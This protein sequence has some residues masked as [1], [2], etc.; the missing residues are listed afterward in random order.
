VFGGLFVLGA[1]YALAAT[2]L[3]PAS[4]AHDV[5]HA[6]V[7]RVTGIVRLTMEPGRCFLVETAV[8]WNREGTAGSEGPGGPAGAAGPP[9]AP[10][11]AGPAG[12]VGPQGP[13]GVPGAPGAMG[14]AGPESH[15]RGNYTVWGNT[16]CGEGRTT[17][18]AGVIA[19]V[20]GTGGAT[21]PFC[22]SSNATEAG[23]QPFASGLVWRANASHDS[24]T[25]YG[26]YANGG[27]E[28]ECAVCEGSVYAA[29]GDGACASGYQK[30][31]SGFVSGVS[32]GVGGKWAPGGPICLDTSTSSGW[33]DWDGTF[34]ARAVATPEARMQYQSQN[35]TECTV[36][37]QP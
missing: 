4:A 21:A 33:L 24:T 35:A 37:Y 13:P 30:L 1:G 7:N 5:I 28:F 26:Q 22:L 12:A 18:Y 31:Y 3:A 23:W 11:I 15:V 20:I 27:N 16:S 8:S 36:C 17:L 6:C 19:N 29:W 9:G 10:G 34:V 25:S 14:P 32:G 2:A